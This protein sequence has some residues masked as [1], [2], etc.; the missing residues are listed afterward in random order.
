MQ[1]HTWLEVAQ[2]S[3]DYDEKNKTNFDEKYLCAK[4]SVILQLVQNSYFH[5]IKRV[6]FR[7]IKSLLSV[8]QYEYED[9]PYTEFL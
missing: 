4:S 5:Q 7:S 6:K 1:L 2:A 9:V 8:T 3:L